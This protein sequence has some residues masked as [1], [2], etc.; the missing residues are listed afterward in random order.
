MPSFLIWFYTGCSGA[1]NAQ[2]L[3]GLLHKKSIGII[4]IGDMLFILK[5]VISITE[6][7]MEKLVLVIMKLL[8]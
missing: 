5:I 2:V 6:R 8:V 1:H 7:N 4:I 3:G